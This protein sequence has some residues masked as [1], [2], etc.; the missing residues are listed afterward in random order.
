[1]RDPLDSIPRAVVLAIIVQFTLCVVDLSSILLMAFLVIGMVSSNEPPRDP[2]VDDVMSI[3]VVG[4]GVISVVGLALG[5]ASAFGLYQG[6][7]WG[8]R[9]GLAH[10]VLALI[11]FSPC[12]WFT[13]AFAIATC[14]D[15]AV[16]DWP[17]VPAS[18]IAS[19]FE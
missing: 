19:T 17:S 1:M 18:S 5:L 16:R 7:T 8:R 2:V 6:K 10:G 15:A 11:S 3:M 9:A 14:R 12:N 13:A 4:Y